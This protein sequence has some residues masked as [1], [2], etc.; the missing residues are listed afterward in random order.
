MHIF[1]RVNVLCVAQASVNW[2]SNKFACTEEVGRAK[3]ILQSRWRTANSH[4][5][6]V[7]CTDE[8]LA[9]FGGFLALLLD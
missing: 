6:R 2:Q 9:G 3:N 4:R 5:G 1:L 8:D 7:Q